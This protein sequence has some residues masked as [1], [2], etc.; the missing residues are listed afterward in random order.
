MWPFLQSVRLFKPFCGGFDGLI[1]G[2]LARLGQIHVDD[3]ED[4]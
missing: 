2:P 3:R 1:G 4:Q